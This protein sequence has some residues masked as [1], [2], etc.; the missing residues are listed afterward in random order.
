AF[1]SLGVKR[2]KMGDIYVGNGKIQIMVASEVS[3]YVML[4]FTTVKNAKI[5]LK[6]VEL[7]TFIEERQNWKESNQTV[8]S[9]RLDVILKEIYRISRKDAQQAI[10]KLQVKVNH[11]IVQDNKFQ[12][13]V[14]DLLS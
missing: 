2:D 5:N 10:E 11:K 6:E 3:Q 8:S 13:Q 4:N 7:T 14:G 9:M 1:L 12:L